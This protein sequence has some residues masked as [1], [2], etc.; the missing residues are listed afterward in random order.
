MG[1]GG[2]VRAYS[3]ATQD[4]L[5]K[6]EIIEE[7]I[8]EKEILKVDYADVERVKHDLLEKGISILN[9][10]YGENEVKIEIIK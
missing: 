8:K 6:V 5:Q 7:D 4:A 10:E 3:K 1:T 2:L 9:I